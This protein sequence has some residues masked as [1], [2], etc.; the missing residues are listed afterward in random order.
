MSAPYDAVE[1]YDTGLLEVGDGHAVYW[2]TVGDPGGTAVVYLHGGP[3]SGATEFAR[4]YFDPAAY[5]SVLFDQRGCGRSRPLADGRDADLAHNSTD[6]LIADLERLRVHLASTG[7]WSSGSPGASLS[8]W[9][10]PNATPAGSAR[11][12]SPRSPPAAAAKSPG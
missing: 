11:W 10:T 2:E 12:S 9:L 7:G 3:G 8:G 5:R 1:P 6:H 4:R